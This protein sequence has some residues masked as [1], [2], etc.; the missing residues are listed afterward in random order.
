[1]E[2][3]LA[4]QEQVMAGL[5][6]RAAFPA[7]A[8][9]PA[10]VPAPCPAP[11][12]PAAA[13]SPRSDMAGAAAAPGPAG[14]APA[15]P[16]SVATTLLALVS[17]KTGYP[18]ELLDP[19]AQMEADLGIDSIKRLEILGAFQ[20][21]TGRIRDGDLEHL[22]RLK[23]LRQVIDLIAAGATPAGGAVP[24]APAPLPFIGRVLSHAPGQE[25]VCLREIDVEEDSFLEHHTLGGRVS[26]F[27]EAL[28]ALA[29]MPLTM[30]MEILAEAAATLLPGQR[31]VGMKEVRAH[32]WMAFDDGR[33]TVRI[34][35]RRAA[36]GEVRVELREAQ[37]VSSGDETS[38][39]PLIEAT[40]VLAERYPEAPVVGAFALSGE[41]P[42]RWRPEALYSEGMFHGPSFR[43]VLSVDRWGA[44]GIEATLGAL[45]TAGL[46]RSR[47]DPGFVTD[48]V[49][50]D[51]AGQLVGYWT[52]EHLPTGFNV[53][54]YRLEALD[55]YGP[56]LAVPERVKARARIALVGDAQVRSDIDV[57][58]ADG[59]LRMRLIGWEDRRFELPEALYRARIAPDESALAAPWPAPVARVPQADAFACHL[60]D[61]LGEGLL[62]AHGR[63]WQR[64]LAHL[65]LSRRERELW[66][67]MEAAERRRTEWLL[68]RAA[69][70]D[71]VRGLL[72]E[73]H[74]LRLCPADVEIV[75]GEH[76]QPVAR[77]AWTEQVEAVPLIS[78]SHTAGI[79]AAV[80]ADPAA[81]GGVGIDV[82]R[83]GHARAGFAGVAFT[84][85]E[86]TR[87]AALGDS[88][89]GE[90]ALRFWCAKEALAKALGCGLMGR[91]HDIVA[92][93][94]DAALGTVWLTV[95]GKVAEAAPAAAGRRF[96]VF[97]VRD[98]DRIAAIS[99]SEEE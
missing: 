96:E 84:A 34:A 93:G 89:S 91:P 46:F 49:L 36:A 52:A 53:F 23:T 45:P 38:G 41:R 10:A 11:A 27:D 13:P 56:A 97:T 29:V 21:Q 94:A 18:I 75:S 57:I 7:V 68:G 62:Q 43:G 44:D 82:E 5:L 37:G 66:R 76:G 90:W 24:A 60:V 77:G 8:E 99:I 78:L 6:S 58:D 73:Q 9:P 39:S 15:D 3:F 35:A 42:S 80:A 83:I 64:V 31:V 87:L 22:S 16:E 79:A 74:G 70:K 98:G 88:G 17:E 55:L 30:S 54:P 20:Q 1:M 72:R 33:L 40:V 92:V 28:L 95:E 61:G 2:E 26:I 85:A 81:C 4:T 32:R 47:R 50:L 19:A 59:R 14:S 12:A 65:I 67:S 71:A 48:P 25:L 69:A 86:R 51:A 63:I